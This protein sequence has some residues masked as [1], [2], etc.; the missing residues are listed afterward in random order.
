MVYAYGYDG[1]DIEGTEEDPVEIKD[2]ALVYLYQTNEITYLDGSVTHIHHSSVTIDS[3]E[4]T[5]NGYSV[6][7]AWT[8]GSSDPRAAYLPAVTVSYDG[9][10]SDGGMV[11]EDTKSYEAGDTVTVLEDLPTKTGYT[12]GGWSDGENIYK[13]GDNF[14][15]PA[16]DV[17]LTAQWTAVDYSVTYSG[18][19]NRGGTVPEDTNIYHHKDTVTVLSGKPKRSGYNFAG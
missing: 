5:I 14:P 11:P 15:M 9:N 8:D 6:P 12:F 4:G 10:G 17:T 1:K 3:D 2:D 7:E 16:G 19:G 13:S 18:N